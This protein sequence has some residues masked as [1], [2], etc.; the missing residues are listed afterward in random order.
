MNRM[1]SALELGLSFQGVSG[2]ETFDD[3]PVHAAR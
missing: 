2:S 1:G 3:Y